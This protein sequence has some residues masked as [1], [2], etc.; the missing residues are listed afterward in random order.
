MPAPV[1][2]LFC[3]TAFALADGG[4]LSRTIE[5]RQGAQTSDVRA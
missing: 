5:S 1:V 4:R 3:L 2:D